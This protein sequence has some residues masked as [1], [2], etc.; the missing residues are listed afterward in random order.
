MVKSIK[1]LTYPERLLQIGI[2]SL[3]YRRIRSDMIQVYKLVNNIESTSSNLLNITG[4]TVT[5]GNDKKLYKHRARTNIRR[6]CF[7]HRVVNTWNELPNE[8][9][10]A[11]SLN[12]F[13]QRLNKFWQNPIKMPC[14]FSPKCYQTN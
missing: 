10:N 8:V 5:R 3:E 9:V 7:S 14:K 13:K 11:N 6:N 4:S 2:P 12:T 1:N